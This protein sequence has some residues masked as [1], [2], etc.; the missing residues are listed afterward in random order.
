MRFDLLLTLLTGSLELAIEVVRDLETA[1][2][3]IHKFGSSHTD[4]IVTENGMFQAHRI[5]NSDF[6]SLA[7]FLHNYRARRKALP[8]ASR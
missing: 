8:E 7:Y 2:E 1:I 5:A 3:H 4:V 6:N